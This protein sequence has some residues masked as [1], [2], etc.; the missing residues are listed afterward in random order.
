MVYAAS[1]SGRVFEITPA[2][3]QTLFSGNTPGYSD[4]P[5]LVALFSD[6]STDARDVA[7]ATSGDIYVSDFRRVRRID[8]SGWVSTLAGSTNQGFLNGD[9]RSALFNRETG[10]CVDT[11]GNIYVADT[12]NHCIRKISP[13]TAGIGIADDWQI[14]N[15]GFIGIDP[16]GDPDHDGMSNYGEFWT[17]TD[18]NNSNSVLIINSVTLATN[19]LTRITWTAVPGMNYVI[20]YSS[21]FLS[22]NT[23]GST[24]QATGSV[25]SVTDPTPARQNPKRFYRVL[26]AGF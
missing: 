3:V 12:G 2:G 5:R 18:P 24:L 20:K 25:I 10:L 1:T 26:P 9:G 7:V 16:G 19:N 15:F 11:N 13:D 8:T 21:D 6:G 14:A 17:G 23:L 22:W 4:G